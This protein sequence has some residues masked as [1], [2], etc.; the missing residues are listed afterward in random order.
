MLLSDSHH[1]LSRLDSRSAGKCRF[2]VV[3]GHEDRVRGIYASV[4][5]I[6]CVIQPDTTLI[7]SYILSQAEYPPGDAN[8]INRIA[9]ALMV[10]NALTTYTSCVQLVGDA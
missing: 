9:A 1:N 4:S 10:N 3:F 7:F 5:G 6:T 2:K 8:N